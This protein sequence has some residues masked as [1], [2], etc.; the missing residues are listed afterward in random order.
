MLVEM[1]TPAVPPAGN[2]GN[3]A[4]RDAEGLE[5]KN[6]D[7]D[8]IHA[9]QRREETNDTELLSGEEDARRER[10]DPP[11][12]PI[13]LARCVAT[14]SRPRAPRSTMIPPTDHDDVGVGAQLLSP[15]SSCSP[16][17]TDTA[18]PSPRIGS[19][20]AG[21]GLPLSLVSFSAVPR[22]HGGDI[23]GRRRAAS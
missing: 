12:V 16:P 23:K 7:H 21:G 14:L 11:D 9:G 5:G 2:A 13:A 10:G 22:D 15:I 3:Y 20:R 1:L 6:R 18:A 4:E 19:R 17:E 8:A